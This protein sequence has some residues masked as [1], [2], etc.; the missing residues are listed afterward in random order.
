MQRS[1]H[2]GAALGQVLLDAGAKAEMRPFCIEQHAAQTGRRAMCIEGCLQTGN[3]RRIDDVG[4]R[5]VQPQTQQ[6]AIAIKPDFERGGVGISHVDSNY[7]FFVIARPKAV[8][9]QDVRGHGLP[10]S[11]RNDE[12]DGHRHDE[13]NRHRND[14]TAVCHFLNPC[15]WPWAE[16]SRAAGRPSFHRRPAFAAAA[17]SRLRG[18]PWFLR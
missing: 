2:A 14:D 15:A 6:R 5:T 11:A 8:A 16:S 13:G 1:Q 9:I 3:H 12:G 17:R 4:L 10:R 7:L 18:L